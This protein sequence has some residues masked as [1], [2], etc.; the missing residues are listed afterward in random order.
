MRLRNPKIAILIN[1]TDLAPYVGA[2]L[3][4]MARDAKK[5]RGDKPFFFTQL[6]HSQGVG[7][8]IDAIKAVSGL[9]LTAA[10]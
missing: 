9:G 10:E 5:M 7:P 6:K 4:V 8:V 2:S 1:K 3:E